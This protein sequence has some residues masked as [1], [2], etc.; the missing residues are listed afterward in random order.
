M[1]LIEVKN[2]HKTFGD[3]TNLTHALNGVSFTIQA[4]EI[5]SI[6]GK[7]GCGKSTLLSLIGLL[8]T[9]TEGDIYLDN[10]C[11]SSLSENQKAD[12]RLRKMGYI[13]QNYN[14]LPE[15]SARN[16][17]LIPTYLTG[18]KV[19]SKYLKMLCTRLDILDILKKQPFQ[20]SGGEQQRVAIARALINNPD[21][22]LADEPTGN[23]DKK[24]GELV[25]QYFLELAHSLHKTVLFVT[26][27]QDLALQADRTIHLSDGK[28]I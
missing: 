12:I 1:N 7:S 18:K 16:N 4:G 27:D 3:K 17:I 6:I 24:N 8:D 19:D 13:Y 25:F 14:L 20:L 26:H 21:I 5:V 9:P 11:I 28:I 15:Y 23:L 2:L 22:I 10:T